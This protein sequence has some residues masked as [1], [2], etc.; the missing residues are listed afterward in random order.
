MDITHL[1]PASPVPRTPVDPL[2]EPRSLG[3]FRILRR[4]GDG[5]M[6]SVYLG[7]HEEQG[8]QVAIKVLAHNL[9][10]NQ[11]YVDRFYREA[12]SGALLSH[13]NVVR[14]LTVSQD[15]ASRLHY[16]V[17]EFVDGP[18]GQVLLDRFGR[19]AIGDAVHIALDIARALEH[20]HSRNIIHRDIK[21]G[22]ILV[23]LSGV[24]KLADLGLAKRTD[25][26]SHLTA[27]RQGFGTP[28]YMPYEQAINAKQADGRSDIYALGATI[29][30]MVTGAV[31]FPGENHLEVVEKKS[32][33]NF[34]QASKL[35][36][37][38]PPELD[39]ILN[40]MLARNPKDRYQT[41]SE[42]IIDLERSR[43]TAAVLSFVDREVAL[44]DPWVRAC[45]SS[46]NQA[47]RLDLDNPPTPPPEVE[48]KPR[49]WQLRFKDR[50]GRLCKARAST[51][52]IVRRLQQGRLRVPVQASPEGGDEYQPLL[53]YPEFREIQQPPRKKPRRP[54]PTTPE[55]KAVTATATTTAEAAPE[56]P[57]TNGWFLLFGAATALALLA[58]VVW[59][60]VY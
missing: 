43:L 60:L 20:A 47:T 35:N 12:R 22:N 44:Q 52:Q 50:Q 41:V 34:L 48:P 5:G 2:Y 38:V 28:D 26:A 15:P 31:P 29:Y 39:A 27:T 24:A 45:L 33:G 25:E 57:R 16:L 53:S 6:G 32:R 42:L 10:V 23:T 14:C 9:A 8:C 21:P 40:R 49:Y 59:R 17:L 54:A 30:Q 55:V 11:S 4:L 1:D 19:L 51:E 7:Y 18:S 58:V 56:P 3:E 46:N 13:P 36:P 37:E